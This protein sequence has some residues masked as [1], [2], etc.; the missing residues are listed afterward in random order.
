[1]Y[2]WNSKKSSNQIVTSDL[3]IPTFLFS[4]NKV[5]YCGKPY[6]YTNIRYATE[7]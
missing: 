3:K 7:T 2:L 4:N 1:M 6:A 5:T